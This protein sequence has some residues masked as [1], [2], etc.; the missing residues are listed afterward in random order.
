MPLGWLNYFLLVKIRLN[1]DFIVIL[2]PGV[3]I[4]VHPG[5]VHRIRFRVCNILN[6]ALPCITIAHKNVLRRQLCYKIQALL[7]IVHERIIMNDKN[8]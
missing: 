2:F 7:P 1:S 8:L 4:K 6:A 3:A 5:F